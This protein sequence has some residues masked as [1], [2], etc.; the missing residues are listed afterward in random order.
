MINKLGIENGGIVYTT[1]N[2]TA[3]SDDEL[4]V[5]RG[6]RLKILR[7]ANCSEFEWW[8]AT[9]SDGKEGYVPQYILAVSFVFSRSNAVCLDYFFHI[10]LN[11]VLT[12]FKY[13]T[14]GLLL[15]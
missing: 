2:F 6:A 4:T 14:I 7:K 13:F 9:S 12:H 15:Q 5:T 3:T 11:L 10:H 1:A 8:W